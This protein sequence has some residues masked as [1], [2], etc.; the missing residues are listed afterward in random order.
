M[1]WMRLARALGATFTAHAVGGA[2]W[3]WTF[4]LPASVWQSLI[5]V[6]ITERF[7]FAVGICASYYALINA[8]ALIEKL[9]KKSL[10]LPLDPVFLIPSLRTHASR[11]ES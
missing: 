5:P 10:G 11:A 6:V 1:A 4:A 9:S 2:L 8:L 7:V 3:I